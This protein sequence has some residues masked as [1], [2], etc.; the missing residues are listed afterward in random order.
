MDFPPGLRHSLCL[1]V[2]PSSMHSILESRPP[3]TSHRRY[4][5]HIPFVVAVSAQAAAHPAEDREIRHSDGEDV[6]C[7]YWSGS[8]NVAVETFT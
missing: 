3:S 8:F 5:Q 4:R 1:Y 6:E 7:A 2:T